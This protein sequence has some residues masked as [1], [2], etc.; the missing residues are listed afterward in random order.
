M[1]A[2]VAF[3][4]KDLN[5]PKLKLRINPNNIASVRVAEKLGFQKVDIQKQTFKSYHGNYIDQDV[6]ELKPSFIK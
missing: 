1:Q 2:I 5:L 4:F 6:F 3:C